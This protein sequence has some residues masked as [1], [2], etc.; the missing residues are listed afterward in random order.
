MHTKAI[1]VLGCGID[2]AGTLNPDAEGSV[3]LAID[4]LAM[5]P[6]A[7][8]IMTGYV[9]YKATFTPPISEAQ[10]M[11]DYAVNLGI[12]ESKIFVE[13]ESKD[14]LG[15][16][17]FTKINLLIP[18]DIKDILII[19]GPNQ[20]DKRIDYLATKVL[21]SEYAYE[22]I[23][24]DIA[25]PEE[26]DREEKSLRLAKQWLDP[27]DNGDMPAIYGLMRDR[28]PGYSGSSDS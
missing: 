9:S 7:C 4:T 13:A 12:P 10:A 1:V 23:R 2:T 6:E 27:V 24:P 14:S 21:G 15:N 11:K 8:L 16:L 26:Q 22:I 18:L 17:Y 28:H 20:S 19:R 25:R 3:R 5:H